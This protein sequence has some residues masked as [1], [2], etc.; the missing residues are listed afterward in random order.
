MLGL[1]F[2]IVYKWTLY[3]C[4]VMSLRLTPDRWAGENLGSRLTSTQRARAFSHS[5]QNTRGLRD[6]INLIGNIMCFQ[7]TGKFQKFTQKN[8]FPQEEN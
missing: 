3:V 2:F 1:K 7:S 4:N 5:W 8:S 6:D